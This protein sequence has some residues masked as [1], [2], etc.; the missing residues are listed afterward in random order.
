MSWTEHVPGGG[1]RPD[2]I[3]RMHERKY[4]VR[5]MMAEYIR[6]RKEG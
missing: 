5:S 6:W 1:A 4:D 2:V 3:D